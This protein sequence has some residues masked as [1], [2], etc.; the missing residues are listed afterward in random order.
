M[1]DR[2]RTFILEELGWF[3]PPEALTDDYPLI[4][5]EVIDSMGLFQ[6]VTFLEEQG[7][8]IA[9]DDLVPDNFATLGSIMALTTR[10]MAEPQ[11]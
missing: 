11:L 7:V 9:D 1:R 10:S 2:I 5:R 6:L 4:E 3:E 8:E